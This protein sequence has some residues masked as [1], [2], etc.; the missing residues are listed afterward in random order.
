MYNRNRFR[1]REREEALPHTQHYMQCQHAVYR[2]FQ[3]SKDRLVSIVLSC[4]LRT[5]PVPVLHKLELTST[6][7]E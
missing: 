3:H 6:S 1:L 5:L 7:S 2:Q 4:R